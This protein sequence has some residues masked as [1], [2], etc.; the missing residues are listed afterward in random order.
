MQNLAD[1]FSAIVRRRVLDRT[2]LAGYFDVKLKWAPDLVT[3]DSNPAPASDRGPSIFTAV[4]EQLGL[5]LESGKAP[6]DVLVIDH[7]EH[8]SEN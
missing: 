6:I 7:I 1:L 4:D 8:A 5:K 2:G 3:L